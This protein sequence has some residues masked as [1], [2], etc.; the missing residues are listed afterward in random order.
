MQEAGKSST[1]IK[2]IIPSISSKD[3]ASV[4][5]SISSK[6]I[7][8][9]KRDLINL[10]NFLIILFTLLPL[11]AIS[12]TYIFPLWL[13]IN[14][15]TYYINNANSNYSIATKQPLAT[16]FTSNLNYLKFNKTISIE[17]GLWET[18]W[19]SPLE[20]INDNFNNFTLSNSSL[21]ATIAWLTNDRFIIEFM[22]LIQINSSTLF[23]IQTLEI[24]HLI[25]TFIS[26]CISIAILCFCLKYRKKF[27]YCW[28]I[29]SFLTTIISI[30]LG[31]AVVVTLAVWQNNQ[32]LSNLYQVE[33]NWCY[34]VTVGELGSLSFATFLIFIY[35][36]VAILFHRNKQSPSKHDS[37]LSIIKDQTESTYNRRDAAALRE[38]NY[39]L[40]RLSAISNIQHASTMNKTQKDG[41]NNNNLSPNVE[42]YIY[43]NG[44]N[45]N[46]N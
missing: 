41:N 5:S 14:L 20:I 27:S 17:V 26:L 31:L 40:P 8:Y 13:T 28:Y 24:L 2:T 11:I 29:V 10:L 36:L 44:N 15:N 32:K 9:S 12:I 39:R 1:N 45:N 6:T 25:F 4:T 22:S 33:F 7:E 46:R 16:Q 34:W 43:Y 42:N 19:N 30:S 21:P 35:I 23:A 18:K 3:I 38:G 37:S